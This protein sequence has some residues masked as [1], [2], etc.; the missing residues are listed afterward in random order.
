M[1]DDVRRLALVLS[2]RNTDQAKAWDIVSAVPKGSR[3]EF[4]CSR[5]T[6]EENAR[7]LTE[8]VCAAVK[9]ALAEYDMSHI[10]MPPQEKKKENDEAEEIEENIL[11]FIT[12]LQKE[13]D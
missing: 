10:S 1:S 5:I 8:I 11:G 9:K 2:M 13:G 4:I 7:E 12:A 3:T 6:A